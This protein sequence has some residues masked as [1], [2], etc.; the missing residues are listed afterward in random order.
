MLRRSK[1][2][3]LA[4]AVIAASAALALGQKPAVERS[5]PKLIGGHW[6]EEIHCQVP[7][8]AGGRLVL[9]AS[10][11]SV[12]VE[13][14][15]PGRV[16]CLIHLN[17][18]GSSAQEA[19]SCLTAYQ[20]KAIQTADGA[21]V[22]GDAACQGNLAGTSAVFDV[23]VPLK[24][25]LD[26]KT[27]GGS[28][29]VA[30]LQ[31]ELRAQTRGGDIRTGNVLGPVRVATGGGTITLGNIG[32][33]VKAQTAG[34][35]VEV[36][37]VG[38][39]AT[40]STGG[41]EIHAGVINGPVTAQTA[42]GD[43]IL[44]AAAGPVQAETMGGQIHLGE[45]GNSV[46]AQT[47]G[48]NI[49]VAGA[50]GG[51]RAETTGGSIT[52]LKAMSSVDAQTS[53]GR[54]LAQIDAGRSTFGPSRLETQV[55]DVD[56]FLPPALP[57]TI[58]ALIAHSA[59]NRIISDFP[60]EIS[61]IK[62]GFALAQ[63]WAKGPIHGGGIPLEIR[64]TMGNIQIR[65]MDPAA[66]ARI[67]AAQQDFWSQWDQMSRQ[68]VEALRQLQAVQILNQAQLRQLETRMRELSRQMAERANEQ[69]ESQRTEMQ[70]QL[71]ELNRQLRE[72]AGEPVQYVLPPPPPPPPARP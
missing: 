52:L 9:L 16:E 24:F 7:V 63:E 70:K 58:D 18:Y 15:A 61:K 29:H 39:W 47:A 25:N 69:M 2:S 72:R 33:S 42:G 31:G 40:I 41:G 64:T 38:S 26:V 49:E 5:T 45:C 12:T 20:V 21:Y 11:G 67:A 59:G 50:R 65:K 48:G 3:L 62:N 53:A 22:E 51:V 35:N 28:I 56:V 4:A 68:R 32:R 17:T 6:A 10:P 44:Q 1:F 27:Q 71:Q 23:K 37:N 60:L 57:V 54:I 19:K 8:K 43:I 30:E 34:G 55:G 13:P 46:R 36:G 14:G 66:I